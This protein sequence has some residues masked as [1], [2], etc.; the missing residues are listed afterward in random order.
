MALDALCG[1]VPPEI[2]P[3]ITK[4]ET[5]KEAWDTIATLRVG[6]DRVKKATTQQ[7]CHKFDLATFDDGETIEDYAPRLSGMVAHLATLGE[8]VKVGEIIAKM[9]QSLPPCFKQIAIKTLLDVSTMSIADLTWRFKGPKKVTRGGGEW[10]PIKIPPNNLA[11]IPRSSQP[12]SFLTRPR[13]PS[14]R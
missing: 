6:D 8:E 14:Y 10:E 9:L 13:P 12:P 1:T 5:A 11:Y 4:K 7:L 3:T 2:V